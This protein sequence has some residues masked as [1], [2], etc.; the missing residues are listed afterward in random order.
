MTNTTT[1]KSTNRKIMKRQFSRRPKTPVYD[2]AT[3]DNN[4]DLYYAKP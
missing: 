1:I 4:I 3:P 2:P